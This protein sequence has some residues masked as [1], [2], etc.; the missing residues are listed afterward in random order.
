M[1]TLC[2]A[3]L[4]REKESVPKN[5]LYET[6][7]IPLCPRIQKIIE[8]FD[9][10]FLTVTLIDTPVSVKF[11][12]EEIL[13]KNFLALRVGRKPRGGICEG[14]RYGLINDVLK[15]LKNKTLF[16]LSFLRILTELSNMA[17]DEVLFFS[18]ENCFPQLS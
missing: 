5:G 18:K 15:C 8:N 17:H 6:A 12:L 4:S 7:L 1:S 10:K 11:F 16:I 9:Q 14:R 2:T 3:Y 13:L